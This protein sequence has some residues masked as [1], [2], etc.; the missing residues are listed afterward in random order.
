MNHHLKS[1]AIILPNEKHSAILY[2]PNEPAKALNRL[3]DVAVFPGSFHPLH[4]GHRQLKSVAEQRLGK[5]VVYEISVRNVEKQTLSPVDL[6]ARLSQFGNATVVVTQ[7]A[8]F[9]E[10]ALLIPDCP[11]VVGFDTAQRMLDPRF[12]NND[13]QQLVKSMQLL[14]KLCPRVVVGGRLAEMKTGFHFCGEPDLEVPDL[15]KDLFEF[16]PESEFRIDVSSS[17]L[18]TAG[19]FTTD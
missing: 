9:V 1:S 14:K 16:I 11:F 18:R 2:R 13:Q 6:Q 17:Q 10:K 7:A 12:Y 19:D 3:S 15:C 8:R 4:E 5:E